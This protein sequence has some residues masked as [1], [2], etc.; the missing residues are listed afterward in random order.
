MLFLSNGASSSYY[1]F[2][3]DRFFVENE[4]ILAKYVVQ[5]GFK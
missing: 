2:A 1:Y 4:E 5:L 3:D